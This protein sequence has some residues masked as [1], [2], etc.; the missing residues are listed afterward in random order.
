[1]LNLT[2]KAAYLNACIRRAKHR[3]LT[4]VGQDMEELPKDVVQLFSDKDLRNQTQ[5]LVVRS[6]RLQPFTL[7]IGHPHIS[8]LWLDAPYFG[9]SPITTSLATLHLR[10]PR[11]ILKFIENNPASLSKLNYW[12]ADYLVDLAWLG[13]LFEVAPHV[14][15]IRLESGFTLTRRQMVHSNSLISILIMNFNFNMLANFSQLSCP[16]LEYLGLFESRDSSCL[17][18][19][20]TSLQLFVSGISFAS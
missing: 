11:D 15:K 1:M 12:R 18:C 5:S 6:K 8:Q 16:N 17:S 7:E 2:W 10:Y 14:E 13:E 9:G 4:L 20:L 19:P 3:P